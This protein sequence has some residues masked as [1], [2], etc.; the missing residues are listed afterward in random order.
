MFDA[1]KRDTL[2]VITSF[3][4]LVEQRHHLSHQC[5]IILRG[6]TRPFDQ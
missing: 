2:K 5:G 4:D 6:D 1:A 3:G